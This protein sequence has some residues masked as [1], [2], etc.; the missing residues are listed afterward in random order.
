MFF[1]VGSKLT[2][3]ELGQASWCVVQQE[4][5]AHVILDESS[6]QALLKENRCFEC[7]V[8]LSMFIA[9]SR[10]ENDLLLRENDPSNY[11]KHDSICYEA[12]CPL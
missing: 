2:A 9:C 3:G 6:A 4:I 7:A 11:T 8:G 10:H 5:S 1:L 12:G